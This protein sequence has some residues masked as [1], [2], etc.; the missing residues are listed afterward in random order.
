MSIEILN[1]THEDEATVNA[2]ASRLTKL[3]GTVVGIISNGKKNTSP[4]FDSFET[5]LK[6]NYGVRQV[7]RRTKSNYSSPAEGSIIEEILGWDAVI[8][9]VGD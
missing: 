3:E 8:A 4:F 1:P 5:Y 9:G 6:L 7:I 2:V